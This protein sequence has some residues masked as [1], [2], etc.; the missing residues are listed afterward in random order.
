MTSNDISR[1]NAGA[2]SLT[3]MARSGVPL[4]SSSLPDTFHGS[5]LQALAQSPT[6]E[7]ALRGFDINLRQL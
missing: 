5:F 4:V 7:P 2:L 6:Y 1:A 3:S